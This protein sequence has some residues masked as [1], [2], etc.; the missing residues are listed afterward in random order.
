MA[1]PAPVEVYQTC[2]YGPVLRYELSGLSPGTPY[3]LRLHWAE[4]DFQNVGE[5]VFA[6]SVDGV[7]LLR[8][9]DVVAL[10]G[11][12]LRAV[13]RQLRVV[14]GPEGRVVVELRRDGP[15]NPFLSGLEVFPE[16]RS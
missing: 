8:G 4:L 9:V 6:V 14:P 12:R 2:R 5:R 1:G 16:A 13:V 3:V 10:A 7:D 11:S 15:D